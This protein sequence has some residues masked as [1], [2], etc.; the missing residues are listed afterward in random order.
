M[1]KIYLLLACSFIVLSGHIVTASS[2]EIH[3]PTSIVLI[4]EKDITTTDL[5]NQIRSKIEYVNRNSINLSINNRTKTIPSSELGI[6][7]KPT[8]PISTYSAEQS[9]KLSNFFKSELQTT[10]DLELFIDKV[11]L[12]KSIAD[13]FPEIKQ[14]K[15]P[16]FVYENNQFKLIPGEQGYTIDALSITQDFTQHFIA[17]GEPIKDITVPV[18]IILPSLSQEEAETYLQKLNSFQSKTILLTYTDYFI[19]KNFEATK[20]HITILDGQI[21]LNENGKQELIELLANVPKQKK[22]LTII[23]LDLDNNELETEGDLQNGIEILEKELYQEINKQ[24]N[25]DQINS[26]EI[27]TILTKGEIVDKTNSGLE[28]ELLGQG[29]SNYKASSASR[30]HNVEFAS[31][32]RYKSH[33]VPKGEQFKFNS[34]LGGPITISR[35]WKNAFII[36]G[37]EVVPGVGGGICQMSTTV[38]RAALNSGLEINTHYNHSLYVSYYSHYGDGLDSTI[39]P[40]GKDLIFT[41]NTPGPIIMQSHYN[42]NDDLFVNIIGISDGRQITLEGPFYRSDKYENPYELDLRPNQIGWMRTITNSNGEVTQE[43]LIS[44]F[45]KYY[46]R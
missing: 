43:E 3:V 13:N 30:A 9:F 6:Y 17:T 37:G 29:K 21:S 22:D 44:R 16:E 46:K 32:E 10:I 36:D 40:G 2:E 24:L 23:K 8:K 4:S 1:K 14:S 28:L 41:N 5:Q 7:I 27:P 38:Y 11:E 20:K 25:S 15:E 31:D 39:F 45:G 18:E 42:D 26:V 34:H 12:S 35:G 19:E 33:L